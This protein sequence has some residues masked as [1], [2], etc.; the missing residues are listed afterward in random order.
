MNP[1]YE[2]SAMEDS[3]IIRLPRSMTDEAFLSGL[4]DYLELESL[5]RRSVISEK[6]CLQLASGIKQSAWNQ[7][8]NLFETE[9]R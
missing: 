1:A 3:I 8:R 5:K 7:V 4:L 2:I 9:N 6:E